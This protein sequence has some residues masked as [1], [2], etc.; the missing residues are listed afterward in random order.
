M[1]EVVADARGDEDSDVSGR[2]APFVEPE[3][4]HKDEHHLGDAEAVTE[5][6]ERIIAVSLFYSRL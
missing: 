1:V 3:A 5:V 4:G 6:V 2:E